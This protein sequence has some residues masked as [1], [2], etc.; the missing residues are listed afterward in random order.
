MRWSSHH[1]RANMKQATLTAILCLPQAAD[2]LQ[3]EEDPIISIPSA[4][5]RTG[6]CGPWRNVTSSYRP[7]YTD[8]H[9]PEPTRG[10]QKTREE[11][12]LKVPHTLIDASHPWYTHTYLYKPQYTLIPRWRITLFI[13]TRCIM[14]NKVLPLYHYIGPNTPTYAQIQYYEKEEIHFILER[15]RERTS[16]SR[17]A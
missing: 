13:S 11:S 3:S 10:S 7:L 5:P 15:E 9:R 16:W 12:F 6:W 4:I 8:V 2:A 17:M 1:T 14:T